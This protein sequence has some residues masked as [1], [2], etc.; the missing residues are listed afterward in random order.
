DGRVERAPVRPP[1]DRGLALVRDPD[2]GEAG[3]G[4]ARFPESVGR[5]LVNRAEDLVGVVL[6]PARLRV[7]LAD[8]AVPAPGDPE[9]LVDDEAGR[10]GRPL[11]DREDHEAG[12]AAGI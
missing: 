10:P 1:D 9:P 12:A 3:G 5:R 6:D 7:G 8:L 11:V 2:R 4:D